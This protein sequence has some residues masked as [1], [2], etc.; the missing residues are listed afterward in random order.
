MV[1]RGV[2]VVGGVLTYYAVLDYSSLCGTYGGG[3]Y[4]KL[5]VR[6]LRV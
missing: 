1:V 2:C 4:L 5:W 6:F 3:G